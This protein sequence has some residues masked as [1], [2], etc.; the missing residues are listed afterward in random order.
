ML[1]VDRIVV[2][3]KDVSFEELVS[4]VDQNVVSLDVTVPAIF[5]IEVFIDRLTILVY[6][7]RFSSNRVSLLEVIFT[8][9]SV[10]PTEGHQDFLIDQSNPAFDKSELFFRT[11]VVKSLHN[12]VFF[13]L[14]I[15]NSIAEESAEEVPDL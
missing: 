8:S 1:V 4:A 13:V 11:K 12:E 10:S 14:Q 15:M 3:V 5:F 9:E 7:D 2:L 6:W